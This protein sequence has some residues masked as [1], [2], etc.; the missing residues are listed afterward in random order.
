ML[1]TLILAIL[2]WWQPRFVLRWVA[3]FNPEVLFFVQTEQP[4]VALT[5]DD[6]PHATVTPNILDVLAKHQAHA[7]FFV[8]G[9]RVEGNE[10]LLQRMVNEGHEIGNHHLHDDPSIRLSADEFEQQLLLT[11]QRLASFGHT[12]WF[13]PA[14][15]WFNQRILQQLEQHGYTCVLG[16]AYAE[17][18]LSSPTYLSQHILFNTQPGSIIILHD[19]SLERART[20]AVLQR[21]LPELQRRG[22][23]VVTVSELLAS[24]QG[25][26]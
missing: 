11:H 21:V 14:S 9:D 4:L 17:D 26:W 5:I 12:H 16:S 2:A 15:G 7:T 20:V 18:W 22:Y 13:R 10:E 3:R 1:L 24:T 8:I 6:S 25:E 19:G 23:R